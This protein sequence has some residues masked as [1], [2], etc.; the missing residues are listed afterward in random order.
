M[1]TG[2]L[3]WQDVTLG[4]LG[5]TYAQIR[6]YSVFVNTG[7]VREVSQRHAFRLWRNFSEVCSCAL[8]LAGLH[9]TCHA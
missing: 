1:V 9:P 2:L 4:A 7:L 5:T 3:A 8:P 6:G